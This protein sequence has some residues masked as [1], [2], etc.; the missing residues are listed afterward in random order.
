MRGKNPISFSHSI[1]NKY[2]LT[3]YYESNI[4]QMFGTEDKSVT[5]TKTNKQK[6]SPN[7]PVVMEL[8]FYQGEIVNKN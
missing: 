4:F 1:F 7:T 5:K 8:K 3:S 2:L 6:K